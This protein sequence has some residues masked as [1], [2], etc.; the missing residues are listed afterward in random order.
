MSPES[1]GA[2]TMANHRA[3]PILAWLLWTVTM[4]LLAL[5]LLLLVLTLDVPSGNAWAPRGALV[6]FITIF[7]TVGALVASRQPRNWVGWLSLYI[8]LGF[9]FLSVADGYSNY[10][11]VVS[12]G[13]EPFGL[14]MAWLNNWLWIL[15]GVPSGI[16]LLLSFP[17]GH[18]LSPRWRLAVG[19]SI[20]GA[21]A[22]AL[23]FAFTPGQ[24]SRGYTNFTNPFGFAGPS[25]WELLFLNLGYILIL[26]A[27]A[28]A[29]LALVLRLRRAQ[30]KERQQLKW[31][32]YAAAVVGILAPTAAMP[33]QTLHLIYIAANTG[34]PLSVG[35]AILR[36][37]L[38]D[39][40]LLINRTL[41]YVP[42]TAILAG[43]FA[44]TVTFSQKF[45][46]LLGASSDAS[47]VITT[48]VV[49]TV[50]TPLKDRLQALVDKRFKEADPTKELHM[51][52]DQAN[53]L[54]QV[55]DTEASARHL[56]DA[57][58]RAFE[59]TG[60]AV[61]LQQNGQARLVCTRG[62]W[63]DEATLRVPLESPKDGM[64]FGELALGTRINGTD[65]SEQDRAALQEAVAPVARALAL[66]GHMDGV[67]K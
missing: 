31:F 10:T 13:A 26:L 42:L 8:G 19:V 43:V 58:V 63:N 14:V 40:D 49:V 34:I 9:A 57:A 23:P 20:L 48:L 50:F 25:N 41:V 15:V 51:M 61:F 65:Y 60:G 35:I 44:A 11:L 37:S 56:L 39:I 6:P 5:G 2:Q 29:V 55:I 32:V 24:F 64:R 52:R 46:P 22:L 59:A 18:L 4:I 67:G 1:A 62:K 45:V 66:I 47:I 38:Y 12:P 28:A 16:F 36:Y 33:D 27:L 54:L 17:N 30:G 21:I 53:A 3:A 7:A